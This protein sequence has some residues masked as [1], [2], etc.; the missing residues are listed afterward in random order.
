VTEPRYQPFAPSAPLKVPLMEGGVASSF[1]EVEPFALIPLCE[2]VTVYVIVP[3]PCGSGWKQVVPGAQTKG[4][5]LIFPFMV[6]E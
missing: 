1:Q 5:P 4:D 2:A 3:L 6:R